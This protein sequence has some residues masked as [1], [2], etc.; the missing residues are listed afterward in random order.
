MKNKSLFRLI[1]SIMSLIITIVVGGVFI[2]GWYIDN[3]DV[4]ISSIEGRTQN[5]DFEVYVEKLDVVTGH[6]V[7]Y[8]N[9]DNIQP[10]DINY[11]RLTINN[12]TDEDKLFNA[13]FE[14]VSSCIN[15]NELKVKE[16]K[17]C[18]E[19]TLNDELLEL[20]LYDLDENNQV[21]SNDKVIYSYQNNTL[22]LEDYLI[23]DMMFVYTYNDESDL[24]LDN[25]Y[26]RLLKNYALFES[27]LVSQNSVGYYYFAL[28]F[29]EEATYEYAYQS[30]VIKS[31]YVKMED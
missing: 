18:T 26:E 24:T 27:F 11:F 25:S 2:Y 8:V 6:Y 7:E 28:K 15:T 22:L 17:I 14:G 3:K 12:K 1:L 9:M 20:D 4:S 19:Y 30:L 10:G 13:K 21:L 23:Q 31:I 29:S 16:N 5:N